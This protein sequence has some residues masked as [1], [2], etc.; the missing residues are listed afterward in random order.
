MS[1][2]SCTH[3]EEFLIQ[4]CHD[5]SL[6]RA[7][8]G[9]GV[10]LWHP[11]T[12]S[13][14]FADQCGVILSFTKEKKAFNYIENLRIVRLVD[15]LRT[16]SDSVYISWRST[17]HN[18]ILFLYTYRCCSTHH[19]SLH[20]HHF[21]SH[22]FHHNENPTRRQMGMEITLFGRYNQVKCLPSARLLRKYEKIFPL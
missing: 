13:V 12:L 17:S 18:Q 11:D 15:H 22:L 2:S 7:E 4:I 19:S 20:L 3:F 5:Y 6:S 14:F 21:H 16:I 10:C 8:D 1:R 9:T